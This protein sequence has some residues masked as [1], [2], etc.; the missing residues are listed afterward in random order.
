MNFSHEP[1]FPICRTPFSPYLTDYYDV[2]QDPIDLSLIRSRL[3]ESA[4]EG[5]AG[6]GGGGGGR[7][8][9]QSVDMFLADIARMCENCRLYN[10]EDSEY[11]AL[12]TK[13]E[14][15]ARN[16]CG[17]VQCRRESQGSTRTAGK[18]C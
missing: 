15:F 18:L 3:E 9:Y 13:L 1:I 14:S 7:G 5:A 10:G 8:Y 12:A 11:W 16:R 2:I 4:G 6:G 17:E